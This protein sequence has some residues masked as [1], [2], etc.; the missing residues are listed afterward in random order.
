MTSSPSSTREADAVTAPEPT[1]MF[2]EAAEAS[3]VVRRQFA[4]N[5]VAVSALAAELRATPPRGVLTCAR[6]SSDHAATFGK[7]LIETRLGVLTT[8]AAPSISSV[9]GASANL[10]GML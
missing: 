5:Q 8:S 1:R 9:Y 10:G 2:A 7:Y 4:A 3:T 6:G